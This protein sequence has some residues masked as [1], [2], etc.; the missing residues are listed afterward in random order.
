MGRSSLHERPHKPRTQSAPPTSF[1]ASARFPTWWAAASLA[2]TIGVVYAP[3]ASVPFIFDDDGAIVKNTSIRS[4]WPLVGTADYRGPLN[5][6]R[7]NAVS[8]RPLVNLTLAINYAVGG[9]NP[10]GYHLASFAIHFCSSLLLFAIVRRALLLPYFGG[11]FDASADW[12]AFAAALLWA[13]HPLQTEAVIYAS[14][15]TELMVALFYLG[16]LYSSL[17]YWNKFPLPYREGPGEGSLKSF[18]DSS[19]TASRNIWLLLAILACAAGMASKEVMI[20]APLVVLLF[21]RVFVSGSVANALRRSWP[22]YV[23][24]AATWLLLLALNIGAPRRGSAGFHLNVAA[25]DYWLTQT[26]VLLMYLKLVVWPWPLLIHYELPYLKT[27]AEAWMYVLPMLILGIGTLVLLWRNHP[28]GF[29]GAAIFAILSATSVVPITT[30]VAAERRMY[31]P[32]A[33]IVVLVVIGGHLLAARRFGDRAVISWKQLKIEPPLIV[34]VIAALSL[35]CGITSANRVQK[36]YYPMA[37]WEEILEHQPGNSIAHGNR[38]FLLHEAGNDAEAIGEYRTA[39]RLMPDDVT[40]LMDLSTLLLAK[41]DYKEAAEHLQHVVGLLPRDLRMRN[42][43]AAALYHLHRYDDAI[44]QFRIALKIDPNNWVTYNN[45]GSALEDAGRYPEAIEAMQTALKI[46]P[47]A[48][49]LYLDI[50]DCYGRAGQ[51]EKAAATVK[52]G[53]QQAQAA[54]DAAAAEK[55]SAKLKEFQP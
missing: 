14:Q 37:I 8:G 48:L 46:N 15:R 23:G 4:L 39:V 21:D 19:T 53:L 6:P 2:I 33:A 12:L 5:P 38:A 16:T 20:S 27:L 3:A 17:R 36:F 51:K 41:G 34:L 42:N 44:A 13:L 45:L 28:I 7:D 25:T 47:R 40:T 54:G 30:E 18:H 50:A 24:L 26:K 35:A 11:Q 29:L 22:L 43:L 55:L 32:L 52:E 49:L 10:T 1:R 31:L 9:L